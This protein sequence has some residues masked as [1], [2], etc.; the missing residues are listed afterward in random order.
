MTWIKNNPLAAYCVSIAAAVIGGCF[1]LDSMSESRGSVSSDSQLSKVPAF[2]APKMGDSIS[3][4]ETDIFGRRLPVGPLLVVSYPDCSQCS[5]NPLDINKLPKPK[6]SP[7]V[8]ALNGAG[9]VPAE[10]ISK[11]NELFIVMRSSS[12]LPVALS[13]YANTIIAVDGERKVTAFAP[14]QTS[15]E[16]L[17]RWTQ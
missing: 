3:L 9:T 12:T 13:H 8:I 2:E 17:T 10:L 14:A 7:V 5:V 1:V 16:F 15:Q 4:P 11:Q 6:K